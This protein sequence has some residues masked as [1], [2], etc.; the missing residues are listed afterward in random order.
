MT[1]NP[2]PQYI[3]DIKKSHGY[4]Y[5]SSDSLYHHVDRYTVRKYLYGNEDTIV[6]QKD[7]RSI[8][9]IANDK[10]P[11][12]NDKILTPSS[13]TFRER[14]PDDYFTYSLEY[15]IYNE[16][17]RLFI[18]KLVPNFE[19]YNALHMYL[20]L[21]L[22]S[23]TP[24]SYIIVRGSDIA[25]KQLFH[26]LSRLTPLIKIARSSVYCEAY[27]SKIALDEIYRARIVLCDVENRTLR[28]ANP[29]YGK[30]YKRPIQYQGIV[31]QKEPVKSCTDIIVDIS[32]VDHVETFSSG[33]ILAWILTSIPYI[34]SRDK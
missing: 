21:S 8:L 7:I 9:D 25:T 26:L 27:L 19:Q 3:Y 24:R 34:G 16:R 1:T 31:S 2:Y 10:L 11:I 20:G 29:P 22:I 32:I 17:V 14:T 4:I 30:T 18:R 28:I 6:V 12:G 15:P 13:L 33:E 23:Y 5:D